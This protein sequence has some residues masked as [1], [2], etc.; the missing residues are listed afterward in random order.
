MA[1]NK[2][3]LLRRGMGI[4]KATKTCT[5]WAVG[6]TPLGLMRAGPNNIECMA[7]NFEKAM[8]RMPCLVGWHQNRYQRSMIFCRLHHLSGH[9]RQDSAI[10]WCQ[11]LAGCSVGRILAEGSLASQC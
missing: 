5:H 8:Q 9:A 1:E 3:A 10:A 7:K 11:L 6:G 2:T 4:A